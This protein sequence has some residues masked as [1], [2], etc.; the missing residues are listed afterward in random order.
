MAT[1]TSRKPRAESVSQ[2]DHLMK[3]AVDAAPT[4]GP[5][6]NHSS[7][8]VVRPSDKGG[9]CGRALCC[10]VGALELPPEGPLR[11]LKGIARCGA[12]SPLTAPS[13]IARRVDDAYLSVTEPATAPLRIDQACHDQSSPHHPWAGS[14]PASRR[15]A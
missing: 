5:L 9:C 10:S 13:D 2:H 4:S 15:Q 3:N 8:D 7:G 6:M 12:A 14:A 1:S 11:V